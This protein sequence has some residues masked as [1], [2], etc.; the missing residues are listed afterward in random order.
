MRIQNIQ[1]YDF[2]NII[3]FRVD[4]LDRGVFITG[5]N[6]GGKSSIIEAI[7]YMLFGRCAHTDKGG[8]KAGNMVRDGAVEARLEADVEC[9]GRTFHILNIVGKKT[10][11]FAFSE[12]TTPI[13][14]ERKEFWRLAGISQE[15]AE[16]NGSIGEYLTEGLQEVLEEYL[17]ETISVDDIIQLAPDKEEWLRNFMASL[18]HPETANVDEWVRL[19]GSAYSQ[20]TINKKMLEE[21]KLELN[22]F[23][24]VP[25]PVGQNGKQ[26]SEADRPAIL[27]RLNSL[28]EN[29]DGLLMELGVA[30]NSAKQTSPERL[31]EANLN[32]ERRQKVVDKAKAE[33]D[34]LV[35]VQDALEQKG[36]EA[37]NEGSGLRGR[38]VEVDGLR[39]RFSSGK[40]PTCHS[41]LS[42]KD[43]E[44]LLND[45]CGDYDSLQARLGSAEKARAEATEQLQKCKENLAAAR[46]IHVDAVKELQNSTTI[47]NNWAAAPVVLRPADAV[48]AEIDKVTGSIEKG[49]EILAQL[50]K[51]SSKLELANR[52]THLEQE[53]ENLD[54]CV[55]ALKDRKILNQICSG[56]K[57]ANLLSGFNKELLAFGYSLDLEVDGKSIIATLGKINGERRPIRYCSQGEEWLAGFCITMALAG[58]GPVFL[59]NFDHLDGCNRELVRNRLREV[60]STCIIA[61]AW[62]RPDDPDMAK[63]ANAFN[64]R[65][66]WMENGKQK[67]ECK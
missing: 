21:A 26:V 51:L 40:C 44:D 2:R 67:E 36:R 35:S 20:R 14:T 22:S 8:R 43:I 5:R 58:N 61:G 64:S 60:T 32:V 11:S 17:S 10:N 18:N 33:V 23:G 65:A 53:V 54:W 50:D 37:A 57:K 1:I 19:G 42:S 48:Q 3:S 34:R 16:L 45:V 13:S 12:G 38:L 55:K 25:A 56:E 7:R 29:R 52:V 15:L 4:Q 62:S 6:G 28:Q 27:V 31:K 59:D 24:F 9:G 39:K 63:I 66:I 49:R 41:V 46:R 47:L 30:Q